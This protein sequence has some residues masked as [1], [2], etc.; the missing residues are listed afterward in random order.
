[1]AHHI[2]NNDRSPRPTKYTGERVVRVFGVVFDV[3][4]DGV[5]ATGP[6]G[7]TSAEPRAL[8]VTHTC[9]FFS[10]HD[11]KPSPLQA[12]SL[13]KDPCARFG[14][15]TPSRPSFSFLHA[16]ASV[17]NNLPCITA[18]LASS[19]A[20]PPEAPF[21]SPPPTAPTPQ[22]RPEGAVHHKL[23]FAPNSVSGRSCLRSPAILTDASFPIASCQRSS[24]NIVTQLVDYVED[25]VALTGKGLQSPE[26]TS[27]TTFPQSPIN[28]T[29]PFSASSC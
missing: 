27:S 21:L 12:Q 11:A 28:G 18:S 23:A 22:D 13:C 10:N 7:P 29:S 20:M 16:F 1:M 9:P 19:Y 5:Q 25:T 15:P 24:F 14:D 2:K 8:A 6:E 17:L 26:G 4:R 3:G